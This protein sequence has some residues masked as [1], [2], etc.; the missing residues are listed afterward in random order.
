MWENSKIT[1]IEANREEISQKWFSN[2]RSNISLSGLYDGVA[3]NDLRVKTA[4]VSVDITPSY[5]ELLTLHL[6]VQS[7]FS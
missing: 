4:K 5:G 7:K 3:Y 1:K 2:V 6:L